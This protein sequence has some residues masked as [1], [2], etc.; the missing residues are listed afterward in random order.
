MTRPAVIKGVELVYD[1][2]LALSADEAGGVVGLARHYDG[3]PGDAEVAF[4]THLQTN[5]QKNNNN[6]RRNKKFLN[7]ITTSLCF[8][9]YFLFSRL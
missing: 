5:L 2:G 9:Q 7:F 4:T 6:Q 3:G 8:S 1:G